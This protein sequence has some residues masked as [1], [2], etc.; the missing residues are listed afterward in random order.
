MSAAVAASASSSSSAAAPSAG[1]TTTGAPKKTPSDFLRSLIGRPVIVRLSS[2]V[3]YKG[4]LVCLDGFM[5]V[6]LE[7]TE[8][9]VEGQL[10]SKY[11]DAFLRGNN[12][13]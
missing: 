11:G 1:A 3:D 9:W 12:G 5:N 10:K 6:A 13:E 4:I 2:G 7:Q 8:E